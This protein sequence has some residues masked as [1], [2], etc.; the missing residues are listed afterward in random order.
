M[1]ELE[2]FFVTSFN[3]DDCSFESQ[4]DSEALPCVD[5]SV[6]QA[7]LWVRVWNYA[8]LLL[9]G[10]QHHTDIVHAYLLPCKCIQDSINRYYM[11]QLSFQLI[12]L[13]SL[14]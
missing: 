12:D 10:L 8:L 2:Q 7:I 14:V 6:E 3:A 11:N 5:D 9:Q 13:C 1:K 4:W